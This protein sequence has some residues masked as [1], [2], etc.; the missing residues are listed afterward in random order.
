MLREP[1]HRP[2]VG[3]QD[4][5]VEHEG[6][7]ADPS[8]CPEPDELTRSRILTTGDSPR[9][10]LGQ[11]DAVDAIAVHYRAVRR[12][13]A[14]VQR[15]PLR[16]LAV[17]P[18]DVNVFAQL[19]VWRTP[20]T[21]QIRRPSAVQNTEDLAELVK[22][23]DRQKVD[24]PS[25]GDRNH[26]LISPQSRR[27]YVRLF[28]VLG[29]DS[30]GRTAQ[31]PPQTARVTRRGRTA[32]CGNE[33]VTLIPQFSSAGSSG[34]PDG[35]VGRGSAGEARMRRTGLPAG[36]LA[37]ALV[38]RRLRWTPAYHLRRHSSD[39]D[40]WSRSPADGT[41][42]TPPRSVRPGAPARSRRPRR[43]DGPPTSTRPA[44]PDVQAPQRQHGGRAGAADR[45]GRPAGRD[46]GEPDR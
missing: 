34:V 19:R 23:T 40:W 30:S 21:P 35:A 24:K 26:G 29:S 5:G 1:E 38:V 39:G 8:V 33:G 17:N 41:G 37:L 22:G 4:R 28:L 3:Q 11:R 7:S 15:S 20:E 42:W 31:R 14:E 16:P 45:D 2:R 6:A 27:D 36:R 10:R 44:E 18:L 32:R 9:R 13:Y 25:S 12:R 43:S 46:A